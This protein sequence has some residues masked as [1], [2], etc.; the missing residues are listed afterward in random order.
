MHNL[1]KEA[2]FYYINENI[3][4]SVSLIC[5]WHNFLVI[6]FIFPKI[7]AGLCDQQLKM[8]ITQD[9]PE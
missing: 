3:S 1:K 6:L 9:K 5:A 2:N 7:Y 4:R 8:S